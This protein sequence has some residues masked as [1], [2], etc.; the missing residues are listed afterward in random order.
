MEAWSYTQLK[1]G[2][3]SLSKNINK[4][5]KKEKCLIFFVEFI[6]LKFNYIYIYEVN[7]YSAR[8]NNF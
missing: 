8:K 1:E 2:G 6:D 5:L 7:R 3:L 4:P